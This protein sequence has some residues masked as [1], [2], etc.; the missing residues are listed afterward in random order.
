VI[1]GGSRKRVGRGAANNWKVKTMKSNIVTAIGLIMLAA[2]TG[3]NNAKSPDTVA[4]DVA[5][6]QQAAAQ[7]VAK[8][9][10]EASE[11]DAKAT[12][13]VNDK[14]Q[15]LNNVE[16][17]G[18]YDV[19]MAKAEGAH[20]VA[21]EKCNAMSGDAQRKCKDLADADYDAAKANSKAAE[22]ASTQ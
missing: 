9:R 5:A 10:K 2:L 14:S 18:A 16:A 6:A 22:V 7:Q 4:N 12:D 13:K 17:K 20:K 1:V 15:D 3:C 19:A 21:L 8:A 11:D